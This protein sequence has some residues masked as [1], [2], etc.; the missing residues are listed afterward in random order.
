MV[1]IRTRLVL[2]AL[3]IGVL[4]VGSYLTA[5]ATFSSQATPSHATDT[6]D[7][8][9]ALGSAGS[10]DNRLTIGSTLNPGDSAQRQAKITI[11]NE[12]ATMSAVT[13]TT[14]GTNGPPTFVTNT[15]DGLKVWIAN[16]DQAWTESGSSPNYSYT[17]GGTQADVLGTTG[18]P[19]PVLQTNAALSNLVLDDG[20]VNYLRIRVTFPVTAPVS[21]NGQSSDISFTFNGTPRTAQ[22]R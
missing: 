21:M 8:E 1:P 22:S 18:S 11:D 12:G 14:T 13:L 3:G 7:M 19:V 17:C 6:G 16:C 9:L 4:G 5:S 2:A 10:A 15:T 20:A